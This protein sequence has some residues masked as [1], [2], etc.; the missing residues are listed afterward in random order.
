MQRLVRIG[1]GG[2]LKTESPVGCSKLHTVTL[3]VLIV[4]VTLVIDMGS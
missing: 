2:D 3:K 1:P 4:E